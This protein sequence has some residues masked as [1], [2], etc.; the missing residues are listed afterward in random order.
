MW[1]PHP[2]QCDIP[3]E[4]IDILKEGSANDHPISHEYLSGWGEGGISQGKIIPIKRHFASLIFG[5]L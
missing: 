1:P 2:T 3:I 4:K 5:I